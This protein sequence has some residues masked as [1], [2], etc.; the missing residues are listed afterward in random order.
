MNEFSSI[1]FEV[2]HIVKYSTHSLPGLYKGLYRK[3]YWEASFIARHLRDGSKD[4]K[5]LLEIY[6]SFIWLGAVRLM[7]TSFSSTFHFS[8]PRKRQK[9]KGCL[10]FQGG[11]KMEHLANMV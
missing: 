2:L 3:S 4:S 5:N 10:T 1:L 7:L 11:I 6:N 8:T 9:I